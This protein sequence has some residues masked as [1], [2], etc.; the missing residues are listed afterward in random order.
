MF[1][2]K[3]L[4]G[5]YDTRVSYTRVR[6]SGYTTYSQVRV[7]QRGSKLDWAAIYKKPDEESR[8]HVN[9]S[10]R[11]YDRVKTSRHRQRLVLR[12]ES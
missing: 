12:K 3:V 10:T 8:A 9:L 2:G 11:C 4:R 1:G 7:D 5:L 6:I